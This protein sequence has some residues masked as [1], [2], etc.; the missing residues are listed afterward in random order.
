M[1]LFKV[2]ICF[3]EAVEDMF[4]IVIG[5]ILMRM[6][7]VWLILESDFYPYEPV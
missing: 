1:E 4:S 5:L 3:Y 6:I 2:V 7:P